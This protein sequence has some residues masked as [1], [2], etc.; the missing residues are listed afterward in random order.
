MLLMLLS[1]SN[2]IEHA[3]AVSKYSSVAHE[4]IAHITNVKLVNGIAQSMPLIDILA[5]DSYMSMHRDTT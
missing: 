3:V 1:K 4:L 5:T 2:S